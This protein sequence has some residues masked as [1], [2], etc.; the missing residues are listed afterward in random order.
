LLTQALINR[1]MTKQYYYWIWWQS[2]HLNK[3]LQYFFVNSTY[4]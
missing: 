3:T 4:K 1:G 2:W